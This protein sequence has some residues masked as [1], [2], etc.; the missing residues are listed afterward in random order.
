MDSEKPSLLR[1]FLSVFK[2]SAFTFGG[3]YVIVPLMR[4]RF[5]EELKWIREE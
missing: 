3:G 2:I 5:A 4:R 1:L